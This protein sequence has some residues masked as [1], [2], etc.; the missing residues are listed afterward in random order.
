MIAKNKQK[1][2]GTVRFTRLY[3][4]GPS[5][6]KDRRCRSALSRPL[7]DGGGNRL[8]DSHH[9]EGLTCSY[10]KVRNVRGL[11]SISKFQNSNLAENCGEMK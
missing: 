8:Y 9:S 3:I 7:D 11:F 1:G 5:K 6:P 4:N 2:G 10:S